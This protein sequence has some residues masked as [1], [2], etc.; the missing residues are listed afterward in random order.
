MK[1]KIKIISLYTIAGILALP[2]VL[3]LIDSFYNP[4]DHFDLQGDSLL[5]ISFFAFFL[6]YL[7]YYLALKIKRR[8]DLVIRSFESVFAVVYGLMINLAVL[9]FIILLL[10]DIILPNS[11]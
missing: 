3:Y 9:Y 11:K 2:F 8:K 5:Y 6:S 7:V 1:D 10:A 4:P